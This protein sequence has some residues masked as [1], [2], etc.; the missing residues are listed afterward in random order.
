[1]NIVFDT[2]AIE[3]PEAILNGDNQPAIMQLVIDDDCLVFC[4]VTLHLLLFQLDMTNAG[5]LL[6]LWHGAC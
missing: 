4:L 3:I 2:K 5:S 1:M 6:G